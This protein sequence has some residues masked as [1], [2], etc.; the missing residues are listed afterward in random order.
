[1]ER[2]QDGQVERNE[3]GS[4]PWS[5]ITNHQQQTSDQLVRQAAS[6][7]QPD[8]RKFPRIKGLNDPDD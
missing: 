6:E 3:G 8:H 7:Q 1:M 4:R 2:D 5:L